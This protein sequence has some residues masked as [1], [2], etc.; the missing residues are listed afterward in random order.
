MKKKYA[1]LM[2]SCMLVMCIAIAMIFTVL[3]SKAEDNGIEYIP[4][5]T[6]SSSTYKDAEGNGVAPQT[7]DELKD[8][9]FAGWFTSEDDGKTY[10]AVKKPVDNEEYYAK[11]VP[12]A[13]LGLKAQVT[14]NIVNDDVEDKTQNAIR[15][16]TSLD[17]T[18]Y[19]H[20]GFRIQKGNGEP[21]DANTSKKVYEV[22]YV[23]EATEATEENKL[24]EYTPEKI[25]HGT[26]EYFKTWTIKQVGQG[27]FDTDIT[28]TPYWI[29]LDGT[30]VDGKTAVKTVNYGRSW[31]YVDQT[32]GAATNTAAPYGTASNPFQTLADAVV[33]ETEYNPKLLLKS[34]IAVDATVNVSRTISIKGLDAA[35]TI[36]YGNTTGNMI[37]VAENGNLTLDTLK[38]NGG[39]YGVRVVGGTANLNDVEITGVTRGVRLESGATV[40]GETLTITGTI[41]NPIEQGISCGGASTFNYNDLT[42]S[43][44]TDSA[45]NVFGNSTA[46][47]N[48]GEIKESKGNAVNV[49]SAKVTLNNMKINYAEDA[50]TGAIGI[51]VYSEELEDIGVVKSEINM[52]EV[53][54]TNGP[55]HGIVLRDGASGSYTR[56]TVSGS[57]GKGIYLYDGEGGTNGATITLEDV[58]IEN[59]TNENLYVNHSSTVTVNGELTTEGGTHSFAIY[60]GGKVQKGDSYNKITI[61]TPT[62]NGVRL[63]NPN[64]KLDVGDM[65]LIS[66]GAKGI[67]INSNASAVLGGT[68]EIQ[69]STAE[70]LYLHNASNVLLDGKLATTGGTYSLAIYGGSTVTKGDNYSKIDITSPTSHG[71]RIYDANTKLNVGDMTLTGCGEHGIYM[72]GDKKPTV[73][74]SGTVQINSVA[75]R[76]IQ[77][78]SGTLNAENAT[79]Q[80]TASGL[81]GLATSGGGEIGKLEI[82]DA[83]RLAGTGFCASVQLSGSA[84]LTINEGHIKDSYK[85]GINMN[86]TGTLKIRN[87][88]IENSGRGDTAFLDIRKE[89]TNATID[90][91]ESVSYS[92]GWNK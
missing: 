92:R 68:V 82:T 29:T 89:N 81:Y 54:I 76:G 55:L 10:K 28:V 35:K 18:E 66:C 8:Y 63:Y 71:I 32:E 48:G 4:G 49:P 33:V 50:N 1:K 47:V 41:T 58:N 77:I 16:V 84:S 26:S 83:G 91:D 45:I 59:S 67:E 65:T 15:F 43:G 27:N 6:Y 69:N 38:L 57:N 17:S 30:R 44:N 80:I 75:K 23:V 37:E 36:I 9:L 34:N 12:S 70:N 14:T 2:S 7:P 13:V 39:Y 60:N 46:I 24:K 62:S 52:T 20:I 56:G 64:S 21:Y 86:S 78:D 51:H 25:F 72:G 61:K 79:V 3:E 88:T 19:R 5:Y 53:D 22:L 85:H 90:I 74:L 40:K 31:Y 11:F 87:C 73:T 42:I